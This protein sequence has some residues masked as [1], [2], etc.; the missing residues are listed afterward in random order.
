MGWLFFVLLSTVIASVAS[1]LQRVL[2][3]SD[4]SNPYAYAIIF[5]FLLG[6]LVLVFGLIQGVDFSILNGNVF[7]L[8]IAGALWGSCQV[9]LFKA[10]QLLEASEVMIVS[11]LRVVVTIIASVI[12]LG[13]AFSVGN[14]LG[15]ILIG[16]ATLLV[17]D[18]RNGFKFNKGVWYTFVAALLAGL[19]IVADS[20][21]VQQYNVL[22]YSTFSNLL[23]GFF[24]LAFYPKSLQQW[25][26]FVQPSFLIKMLPLSVLS[27]TQG[28]LYLF[29]LT[30][31]GNT[32]QVGTIRQAS[33]ILTVLLAVVFLNERSKLWQKF[34][35]AILVTIGVFLLR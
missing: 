35:G 25:K 32:A 10:L 24:I 1:I 17:I 14:I 19:A 29:A 34:V 26:S 33:V 28:I 16:V 21:N 7:M 22:A 15:A 30:Y 12:F 2:M 11:D 5:H 9:F 6:F 23:S 8:L 4:K 3:K 18:M 13:E 20:A 27:A 31:G